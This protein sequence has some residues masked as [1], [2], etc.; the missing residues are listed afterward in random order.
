MTAL[1]THSKRD[2]MGQRPDGCG[3]GAE[4]VKARIMLDQCSETEALNAGLG[5]VTSS[6]SGL[7]TAQVPAVDLLTACCFGWTSN[8]QLH[9]RGIFEAMK[10]L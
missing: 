4:S 3:G 7:A 1:R 5:G 10:V 6:D 8:A 2:E 9:R